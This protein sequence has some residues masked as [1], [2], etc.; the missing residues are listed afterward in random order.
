M[1][2]QVFFFFFFFLKCLWLGFHDFQIKFTDNCKTTKL[3][4]FRNSDR[5]CN[6]HYHLAPKPQ[7][8]N[9]FF[10]IQVMLDP[11]H[12]SNQNLYSWKCGCWK[13]DCSWTSNMTGTVRRYSMD[14][15]ALIKLRDILLCFKDSSLEKQCLC[16]ITTDFSQ[17][18]I[19]FYSNTTHFFVSMF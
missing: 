9:V 4:F 18:N 11:F 17:L 5:I 6:P 2:P 8:L 10:C 12:G 14:K 1:K 19:H 15:L 16:L 7:L 13:N 3:R